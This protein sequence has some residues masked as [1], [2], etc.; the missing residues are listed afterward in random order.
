METASQGGGQA[1]GAGLRVMAKSPATVEGREAEGGFQGGAGLCDPT[2]RQEAAGDVGGD[3]GRSGLFRRDE[4]EP[5]VEVLGPVR[6]TPQQVPT[7][8]GLLRRRVQTVEQATRR[9]RAERLASG[10]YPAAIVLR[11][12]AESVDQDVQGVVIHDFSEHEEIRR[13]LLE[14]G[15]HLAPGVLHADGQT[16]IEVEPAD[17][18]GE[19]VSRRLRSQ[20]FAGHSAVS[21]QVVDQF[22]ALAPGHAGAGGGD[23]GQALVDFERQ[24]LGAQLS[25]QFEA[26]AALEV[27]VPRTGLDQQIRETRRAE[28]GKVGGGKPV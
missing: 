4:R 9:T 22:A 6:Q 28:A 10:G 27:G 18:D 11:L 7:R 21:V 1:R 12:S 26:K 17:Q 24:R 19:G 16:R 8:R 20:A 5:E 2:G 14:S 3:V 25:R 23:G 15:R 13:R